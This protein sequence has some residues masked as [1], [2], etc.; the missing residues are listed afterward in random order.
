MTTPGEQ[1]WQPIATAPK[2]ERID[3]W[4]K[5]RGRVADCHGIGGNFWD[6][7]YY[8]RSVSDATHWMPV[9]DPPVG[10]DR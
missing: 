7:S 6:N 8:T 9:P 4:S 1:G 3:M 2:N 10:G 5:A